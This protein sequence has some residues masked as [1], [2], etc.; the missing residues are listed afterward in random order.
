MRR[1]EFL[2]LVGGASV[3][4]PLAA[5]AQ[6]AMPVVGVLGSASTQ[7]KE[8]LAAGLKESGYVDAQKCAHG[9]SLGRGRLRPPARNGG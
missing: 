3:A 2:S 5:Q 6:P 1:R 7:F 9:I 8:A 4:W